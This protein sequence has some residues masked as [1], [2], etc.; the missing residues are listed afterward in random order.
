MTTVTDTAR[1]DAL[2]E[3][4]LSGKAPEHLRTA[5]ARGAL[6]LPRASI[7][8]LYVALCADADENIRGAAQ[9]SLNGLASDDLLEVLGSEDCA[10]EV[11]THF[12]KAAARDKTLAEK[13]AFHGATPTGALVRT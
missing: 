11:L 5:A 4:I 13:I 12:S 9:S 8:R 7:V 2:V 3:A 10:P 1:M 6:P